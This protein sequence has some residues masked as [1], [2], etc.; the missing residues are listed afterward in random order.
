MAGDLRALLERAKQTIDARRKQST[1]SARPSP[2]LEATL[3]MELEPGTRVVDLE[4][5]LAGEILS[6]EQFH[7]KRDTTER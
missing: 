5:G 4:T 1:A 6:G 3:G 2:S 7:I